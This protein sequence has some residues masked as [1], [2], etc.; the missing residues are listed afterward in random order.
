MPVKSCELKDIP[1]PIEFTDEDKATYE[2]LFNES[3]TTHPDV[4]N[5]ERWI[6]HYAIIMYIRNKNGYKTPLSDEELQDIVNKYKVILNE[7]VKEVK[8]NGD[9][10]P[11]L[12]DKENNPIFKDNSYFFKNNEEGNI[13]ITSNVCDKVN[14]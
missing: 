7:E 12:Y 6:I 8:C 13:A 14:I 1:F 11:Y 9:E 5:N 4:Y 2:I 3:K 10:T